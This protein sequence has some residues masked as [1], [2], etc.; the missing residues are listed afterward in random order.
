[1]INFLPKG[2][3][4]IIWFSR[5]GQGAKTA[6]L[7]L[8]E[9]ALKEGYFPQAFPEYGPERSGA[10]MKVYNRI[11]NRF[12]RFRTPIEKPDI[13]IVLDPTLLKDQVSPLFNLKATFLI[14]SAQNQNLLKKELKI[15]GEVLAIDASEIALKYLGKEIPSI[16]ML[17]ALM[18][19]LNFDLKKVT[20]ELKARLTEKIGK[21][22]VQG[23]LKAIV[24]AFI[25]FKTDAKPL[26]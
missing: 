6:A 13:I 1:M 21:N 10:P 17:G 18:G 12:I 16:V 9:V 15:K 5:G 24:E 23:N 3:L 8:G 20:L 14:N 19:L 25:R 11:G 22:L 4:E 2:V 7:L 26:K